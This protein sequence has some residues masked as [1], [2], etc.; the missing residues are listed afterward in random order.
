MSYKSLLI[1]LVV[2]VVAVPGVAADGR[3]SPLFQAYQA[4]L[5][6]RRD[7]AWRSVP[8]FT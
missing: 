8:L 1:L 4:R 2:S 6:A 7:N 3:Q 5:A